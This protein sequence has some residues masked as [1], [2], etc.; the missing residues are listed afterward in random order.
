MPHTP[1]ASLPRCPARSL[2]HPLCPPVHPE[3]VSSPLSLLLLISH[4]CLCSPRLISHFLPIAHAHIKTSTVFTAV[5]QEERAWQFCPLYFLPLQLSVLM[6]SLPQ[7]VLPEILVVIKEQSNTEAFGEKNKHK[8]HTKHF[9]EH[10]ES[11]LHVNLSLKISCLK[12]P[13]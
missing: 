12:Q 8:S 6:L 4:P 5:S 13:P 3:L 9:W 1:P 2:G 7:A 11:K 10:T